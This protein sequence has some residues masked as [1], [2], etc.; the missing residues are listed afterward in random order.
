MKNEIV[1]LYGRVSTQEQAQEGYSISEQKERLEKY[2][3]AHGWT[4]HK[5]YSD[6]GY[7]GGNT[8]RPALQALIQDV[9]QGKVTKVV[10]YK[11]DRLSRSQKDT[12]YLIEDVFLAN[13]VDFVSMTENFDTGTPF[14]R[15]MIGILSVFAQL[16]REQIKER[17]QVGLDAR[18]KD[19]YYH[20]GPYA[21]IGYDYVD[22]EL[23]INEYEAM[24]VRKI[25]ELYIDGMPIYSIYKYMRDRY[26]TKYSSWKDS[27]VRS[28]INSAIYNGK[29]S[30]KGEIYQG[31]H[32]AIIDD[33]TFAAA[34]A[35]DRD[36]LNLN[37]PKHPFQRTTLL[38]GLVWCGHCGARYYCKQ[39]TSKRPGITPAQKYYTCYSRG[40]SA[41]SMIRDPNC[42]N[43]SYNVKALDKL[44]LDEIQALAIDPSRVEKL[45][46]S[47]QDTEAHARIHV[48]RKRLSAIAKQNE[49]LID[50]YALDGI[51][52]TVVSQRLNSLDVERQQ[53]E[54]ELESL[55]A[56]QPALSRE[57]AA[58]TLEDFAAIV[59][60]S[61]TQEQLRDVVH[62]LINGIIID[63]DNVE[64]HWN[65]V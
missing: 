59:A 49:K 43:K 48:I 63:D 58:K 8:N 19:G 22:G 42:K 11:L 10:V 38:G 47:N 17:M 46:E 41:K 53:L 21:P 3:D 62:T 45:I 57:E 52:L 55:K 2:A 36:R 26:Q 5:N 64:I 7:S 30:W 20:G 65:F 12:L 18:A 16:E 32:E 56:P 39:N 1:D 25:Y 35:K 51:D 31:R 44:V 23:I 9:R 37:F 28:C 15:A 27:S 40:K 14:G 54:A 33:V 6:A 13:G 34:R 29:I 24:Q 4:V 50:L 60:G 61:P